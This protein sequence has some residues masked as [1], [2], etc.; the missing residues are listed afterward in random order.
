M[1]VFG[2]LLFLVYINDIVDC[3]DC[4]IKLY[5]DDTIL[6]LEFDRPELAANQLNRNLNNISKWEND[7]PQCICRLGIEDCFHYF[8][9]CPLYN[10]ERE[11]LFVN[12]QRL[13][14]VSLQSLSNGDESLTLEDNLFLFE[15]VERFIYETERFV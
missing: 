1:S 9:Q 10:V 15:H 14:N 3:V 11:K 6:Y 12:V 7:S 8:F 2:P 5:A 4:G 13:C